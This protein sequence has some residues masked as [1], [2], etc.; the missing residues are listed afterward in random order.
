MKLKN[1]KAAEKL[2]EENGIICFS[3]LYNIFNLSDKNFLK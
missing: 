2:E 1:Y 3:E